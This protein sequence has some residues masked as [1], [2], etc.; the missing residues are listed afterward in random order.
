MEQKKSSPQNLTHLQFLIGN[1]LN[2]FL[3]PLGNSSILKRNP[4]KI[5]LEKFS[6]KIE[7]AS[8]FLF[9]NP[10]KMNRTKKKGHQK[11]EFTFSFTKEIPQKIIRNTKKS[12]LKFGLKN[13]PLGR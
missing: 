3:S 8:N 12:I 6:P 1:P 9:E 13:T 5:H 11:I 4:F 10:L 2:F 7:I